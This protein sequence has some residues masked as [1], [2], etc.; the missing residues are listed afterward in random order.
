MA[1]PCV[2]G[3][4]A[5]MLD[6]NPEL[7]PWEVDSILQMTVKPLGA[8]PK[9]NDFGTGR[10]S[11]YQAVVATPFPGPMHDVTVEAILSPSDT[12]DSAATLQSPGR[13]AQPRQPHRDLPG[14]IPHRH[15]LF[16]H[17]GRKP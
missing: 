12:V 7:L 5:L 2:A 15:D 13:G 11:A 14:H 17:A 16:G 1:T 6:K 10:I 4:V 8:Q 9:N 3:T